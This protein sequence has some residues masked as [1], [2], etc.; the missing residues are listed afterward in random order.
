MLL[1][2][3]SPP[4]ESQYSNRARL[5]EAICRREMSSGGVLREPGDHRGPQAH[6]RNLKAPTLTPSIK[7][8]S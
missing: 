1:S 6:Q 4:T 3:V 7:Q 5:Q 2:H 8:C